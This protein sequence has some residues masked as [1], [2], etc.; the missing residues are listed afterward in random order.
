VLHYDLIYYVGN[1]INSIDSQKPRQ[2]NY[3]KGGMKKIL[4]EE[5]ATRSNH[6][7]TMRIRMGEFSIRPCWPEV[8]EIVCKTSVC[9]IRS[10]ADEV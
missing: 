7:T 10:K 9:K 3:H 6:L 5:I 1:Y 2:T 8:L 4:G